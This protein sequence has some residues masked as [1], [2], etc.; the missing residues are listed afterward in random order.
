MPVSD[1]EYNDITYTFYSRLGPHDAPEKPSFLYLIYNISL[2]K[3]GG[4][5]GVGYR[6]IQWRAPLC[7]VYSRLPERGAATR[8]T[9]EETATSRTHAIVRRWRASWTAV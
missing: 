2:C 1:A 7:H 3:S 6:P 4:G 8:T 9:D 5:S